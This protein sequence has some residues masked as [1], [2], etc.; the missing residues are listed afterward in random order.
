VVTALSSDIQRKVALIISHS[1]DPRFPLSAP[2][3]LAAHTR[4]IAFLG[5]SKIKGECRA[6]RTGGVYYV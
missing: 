1:A 5:S 2:K 4:L 3:I 6:F